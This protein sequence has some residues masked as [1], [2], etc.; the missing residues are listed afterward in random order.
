MKHLKSY[1]L[2]ESVDLISLVPTINDIALDLTDE[3]YEVLVDV[4]GE[5]IRVEVSSPCKENLYSKWRQDRENF[6]KREY[7]KCKSVLDRIDEFLI[8]RGLE[9]SSKNNIGKNRA[10]NF[11]SSPGTWESGQLEYGTIHQCYNDNETSSNWEY[12]IIYKPSS[13]RRFIF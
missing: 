8:S 3:G 13:V 12:E 7:E 6:A 4:N 2:F 10:G 5:S 9:L 1:K 11:I